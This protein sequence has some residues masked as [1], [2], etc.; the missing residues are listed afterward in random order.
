MPPRTTSTHRR[1]EGVLPLNV[2]DRLDHAGINLR[3]Q[4]FNIHHAPQRYRRIDV[5]V[6]GRRPEVVVHH[7][8]HRTTGCIAAGAA[9]GCRAPQAAKR[10]A[11]EGIGDSALHVG[12]PITQRDDDH[13]V[14]QRQ[15]AEDQEEGVEGEAEY[16]SASGAVFVGADEK[17]EDEGHHHGIGAEETLLRGFLGGLMEAV[18]LVAREWR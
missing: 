11:G 8:Q 4:R 15:Q 9:A 18:G 1:P 14:E 16:A 3:F 10:A 2:I 5:L 6:Y 13:R 12:A 7:Q 17:E